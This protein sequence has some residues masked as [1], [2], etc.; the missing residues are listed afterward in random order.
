MSEDQTETETEP[1]ATRARLAR[2]SLGVDQRGLARLMGYRNIDRAINH[3][4]RF[5]E[6]GVADDELVRR[7]SDLLQLKQTDADKVCRL[8]LLDQTEETKIFA[9]WIRKLS[10]P[11]QTPQARAYARMLSR[12]K[13]PSSSVRASA[14]IGGGRKVPFALHGDEQRAFEHARALAVRSHLHVALHWCA[15]YTYWIR[16]DGTWFRHQT[17]PR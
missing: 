9:E 5:E 16:P 11:T 1:L 2:E 15:R 8:P 3:I 7:V 6:T 14:G 10:L 12:P 17:P 4:K 13:A